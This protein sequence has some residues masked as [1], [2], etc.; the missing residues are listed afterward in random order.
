MVIQEFTV[1]DRP[2][3]FFEEERGLDNF[4]TEKTK[5]TVYLGASYLVLIGPFN[6]QGVKQ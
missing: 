3:F 6:R 1:R 2:F 5:L 4:G